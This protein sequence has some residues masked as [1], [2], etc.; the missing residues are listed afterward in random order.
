[1]NV[2]VNSVWP[3]AA[4]ELTAHHKDHSK[5]KD[6]GACKARFAELKKMYRAFKRLNNMGGGG[7]DQRSKRVGFEP[8]WWDDWIPE[9]GKKKR[10]MFLCLG[11]QV[12]HSSTLCFIW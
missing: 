4:K 9:A 7:W 10:T 6:A 8:A 12:S 3:E 5:D 11:I 2:V 1:M